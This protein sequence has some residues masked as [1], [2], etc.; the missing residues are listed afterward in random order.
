[1]KVNVLPLEREPNIAL[2]FGFV[3]LAPWMAS[4]QHGVMQEI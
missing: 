2:A 4:I 1:M 3:S